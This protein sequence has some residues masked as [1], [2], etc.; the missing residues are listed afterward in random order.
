LVLDK[1]LDGKQGLETY[2]RRAARSPKM[3]SADLFWP[4]AI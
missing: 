3:L 1:V 2:N 4:A